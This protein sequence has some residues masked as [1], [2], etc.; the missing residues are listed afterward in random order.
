MMASRDLLTGCSRCSAGAQLSDAELAAQV[1]ALA[2]NAVEPT[3]QSIAW[4]L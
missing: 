1:S 3:A 4:A 2:A